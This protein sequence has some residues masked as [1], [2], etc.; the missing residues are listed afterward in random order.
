ML[1]SLPKLLDKNFVVGFFLPGLLAV[2]ATA[3]AFPNLTVFD[4]IRSLAITET[5]F[6]LAVR[7]LDRFPAGSRLWATSLSRSRRNC[8]AA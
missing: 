3:W 8:L 5:P 2:F 7:G 4:P 6:D 1:S